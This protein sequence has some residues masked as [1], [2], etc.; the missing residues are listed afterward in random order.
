MGYIHDFRGALA[1]KLA[2]LDDTARVDAVNFAAD[3]VLASYK[4]GVKEGKGARKK[5]T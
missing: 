4:N 3:A 5:Q 2:G 1:E